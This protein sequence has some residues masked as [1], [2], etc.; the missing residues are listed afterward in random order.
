[1]IDSNAWFSRYHPVMR[2]GTND[3]YIFHEQTTY[4]PL[5]LSP[6]DFV[7]DIG[8]HIGAFALYAHS[9]GAEVACY[10]PVEH[11]YILLKYNYNQ[12]FWETRHEI[13]LG[14]VSRN[15]RGLCQETQTDTLILHPTNT[16]MHSF[17]GTLEQVNSS[18]E[19]KLEK[20]KT[21]NLANIV[22]YHT[23]SWNKKP[24]AIKIDIEGAEYFIDWEC[25][26]ETSIK[27]IALE[28]HFAY[29]LTSQKQGIELHERI[30]R[31]GFSCTNRPDFTHAHQS[32]GFYERL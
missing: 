12:A 1:M 21:Y 10:E 16:G 30:K 8:A 25:L 19:V 27:K 7:I 4:A 28:Y 11:N 29:P 18:S 17:F 2:Y 6:E 22:R 14:G 26:L 13:T 32:L 24:S 23:N 20:I 15:T 5:Q 31:L 3:I 9:L